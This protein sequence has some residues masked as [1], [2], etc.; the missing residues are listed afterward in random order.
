MVVVAPPEKPPE[1]PPPKRL[2]VGKEG[3]FQPGL[4]AQGWFILEHADDTTSTF[5]LRRAE[6]S[7][8]GEIVPKQVSYAIMIDPAKVREFQTVTVS[9]PM[10]DVKVRQP[11]TAVSVLQD[12]YI[13]YLNK[14]VEASLGQFKIPVSWEGYNSSSKILFP[15][16][17][18]VSSQFGDKRDL[19]LR[20]TK[21]FPKW[22]Y[23]AGVFNG[24]G[25]NNLDDNDQK[26]VALRLEVYPIKGLVIGGVTYDSLFQREQA[27]SKDRWEGDVR[28]E[29]GPYLVQAEYIR[30]RDGGVSARVTGQGAYLALG[31]TV[32]VGTDGHTVQPVVRVGFLDSDVDNNVPATGADELVHYDIGVNYYVRSHE[33]KL[34]ASYQRQQFDEKSANNQVILAA[35]VA[36]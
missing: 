21:T 22:G 29:T 16:R 14:Y 28:Y 23:S 31:Y 27:S 2:T 3:L 1:A 9:G 13:T 18:L 26:D 36:Y 12:F 20:L 4:L 30:A 8:K 5:R 32:P 17:A 33:M 10:G 11:V 15:E 34:Q 6:I 25:L 7:V 24:A 35:Q 19:G